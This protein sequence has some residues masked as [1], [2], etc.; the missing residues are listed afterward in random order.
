VSLVD[1][2]G[3]IWMELS[4][5]PATHVHCGTADHALPALRSWELECGRRGADGYTGALARGGH[6]GSS[7][8]GGAGVLGSIG[9]DLVS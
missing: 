3:Q 6:W 7:E 4:R 5:T 2:Y 9:V 1:A 8:R